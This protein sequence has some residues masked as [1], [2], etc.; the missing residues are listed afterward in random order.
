MNTVCPSPCD[1]TFVRDIELFYI[2]LAKKVE[3]GR[4]LTLLSYGTEA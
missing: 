2:A 3:L 4:L 1:T